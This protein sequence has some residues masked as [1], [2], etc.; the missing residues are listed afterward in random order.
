[1]KEP[2]LHREA[3]S[4]RKADVD[5][6]LQGQQ[7]PRRGKQGGGFDLAIEDGLIGLVRLSVREP[8]DGHPAAV[9][10]LHFQLV[11]AQKPHADERIGVCFI[12]Q[13]LTHL[14]VPDHFAHMHLEKT[15]ASVGQCCPLG[16]LPAQA[17]QRDQSWR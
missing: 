17:Q 4:L 14:A 15:R 13:N 12:D 10:D 2:N 3:A 8:F 7:V 16:A 9:T 5:R 11:A 6:Q 1:M